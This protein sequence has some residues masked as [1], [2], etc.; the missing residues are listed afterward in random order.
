MIICAPVVPFVTMFG[1]ANVLHLDGLLG[2]I[3]VTFGGSS[4]FSL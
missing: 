1:L 3:H 2:L 4:G